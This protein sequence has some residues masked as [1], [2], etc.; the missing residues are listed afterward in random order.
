MPGSSFSL[1]PLPA[2]SSVA[3]R[4][5]PS[6]AGALAVLLSTVGGAREARADCAD[7][8]F[9]IR[10]ATG[11]AHGDGLSFEFAP[12]AEFL[13]RLGGPAG[14]SGQGG[15][16]LG[17][18]L[19]YRSA[20]FHTSEFTGGATFLI[21][22]TL[23]EMNTALSAGAGYAQRPGGAS[24]PVLALSA[25]HGFL[26]TNGGWLDGAILY[27]SLRKPLDS[28]AATAVSVGISFGLLFVPALLLAFAYPGIGH[29]R[30]ALRRGR[31]PRGPPRS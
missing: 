10:I 26:T 7:H 23:K 20:S 13:I 6:V 14:A 15:V 4:S 12:R 25:G 3:P 27:A 16:L 5:A 11:V 17:P 1:Q 29:W 18:H 2:T 9:G 28:H 8:P 30:L 31:G 19:E 21:P 24:G 22:W